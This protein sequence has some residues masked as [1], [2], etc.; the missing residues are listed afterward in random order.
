MSSQASMLLS[1]DP[2]VCDVDCDKPAGKKPQKRQ[3][4]LPAIRRESIAYFEQI[5][6]RLKPQIG[7]FWCRIAQ[8]W[9]DTVKSSRAEWKGKSEPR[10]KLDV[11][12]Q[13]VPLH[14]VRLDTRQKMKQVKNKLRGGVKEKH[15]E[16]DEWTGEG[17]Q[18]W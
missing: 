5:F 18:W 3:T 15:K 11:C 8:V 16:K 2:C 17:K 1:T 10:G 13:V 9:A 12:T 4:C 14:A 7:R 6:L